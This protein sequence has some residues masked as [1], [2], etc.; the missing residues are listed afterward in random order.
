M[1]PHQRLGNRLVAR[2]VRLVYGVPVHDVPP[3]RAIRRDALER[4]ELREL[5]YGWPTE[6]MV[7]TARAGLPIVEVEVPSRPRRGGES[8]IAGRA[9]PSVKAGAVMLAVVARYA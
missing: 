9:W 3:M 4:L 1:H 8:K 2:L 5:S 6:M 7:K